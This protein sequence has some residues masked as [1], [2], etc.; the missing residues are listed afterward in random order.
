MTQIRM[1]VCLCLLLLCPMFSDVFFSVPF[2][3][4]KKVLIM[5]REVDFLTRFWVVTHSLKDAGNEV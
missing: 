2:Y 4:L 3:L 1:C 5:T